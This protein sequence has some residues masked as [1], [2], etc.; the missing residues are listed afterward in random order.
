MNKYTVKVWSVFEV[1]AEDEIEAVEQAANQVSEMG[2]SDWDYEPELEPGS[3]TPAG[4]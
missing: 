3:T 1:E 4:R 2:I